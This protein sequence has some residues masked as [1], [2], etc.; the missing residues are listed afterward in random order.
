MERNENIQLTLGFGGVILLPFTLQTTGLFSPYWV[1]NATCDSVG[2][3]YSCCYG[4]DNDTCLNTKGG[5]ELDVRV[6]GLEAT[7]FVLMFLA[8]ILFVCGVRI[9]FSYDED[10]DE[11]VGWF[12]IICCCLLFHTAAG[13][14]NFIGCMLIV[15]THPS[16]QLGWS[17]FLSLISGCFVFLVSI[18]VC[19]WF[20]KEAIR[21]N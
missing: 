19:A 8:M 20:C 12:F 2:L 16:T 4:P 15:G 9:E 1:S 7:A 17:F 5:N 21:K 13:L 14:F 6:L 11:I 3:I 18:L 10:D